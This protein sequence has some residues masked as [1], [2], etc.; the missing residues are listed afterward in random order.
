MPTGPWNL[1]KQQTRSGKITL[2]RCRGYFDKDLGIISPTYLKMTHSETG[3]SQF[4]AEVNGAVGNPYPLYPTASTPA[5]TPSKPS[6]SVAALNGVIFDAPAPALNFNLNSDFNLSAPQASNYSDFTPNSMEFNDMAPRPKTKG[7]LADRAR[8]ALEDA[9][10]E[11]ATK[12]L[13]GLGGLAH[14]ATGGEIE[15][16]QDTSGFIPNSRLSTE[17]SREGINVGWKVNF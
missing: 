8:D 7:E 12:G 17:I 9:V 5:T 3:E 16:R 4:M 1:T 15:F 6:D 14:L 11:T 13:I 2:F 10:G